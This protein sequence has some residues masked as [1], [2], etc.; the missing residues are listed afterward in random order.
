MGGGVAGDF[1][2]KCAVDVILS[3]YDKID[4]QDC[5]DI[6]GNVYYNYDENVIKPIALIKTANR[7]L[8]NLT[9]KYPKLSGMGTTCAGVWFDRNSGLI[10]F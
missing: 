10:N 1:A 7:Y 2:S 8:Y 3:L 5:L 6:V 4:K 9:K